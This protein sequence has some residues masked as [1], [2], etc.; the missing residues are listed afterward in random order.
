M[1]TFSSTATTTVAVHNAEELSTGYTAVPVKRFPRRAL[2]ETSEEKYWRNFKKRTEIPADFKGRTSCIDFC[3]RAPHLCAVTGQGKVLLFNPKTHEKVKELNPSDTVYC[4]RWRPDGKLLVT[5]GEKTGIRLWNLGSMKMLRELHGDPMG[6]KGHKRAVHSVH[7]LSDKQKLVSG[8]DDATVGVWDVATQ[9]LVNR[10]SGHSDYVRATAVHPLNP[11]II[12]SGS[13][14]KTVKVWDLRTPCTSAGSSYT[15]SDP[16]TSLQFHPAGAY[17]AAASATEVTLWDT[18]TSAASQTPVA[19]LAGHT[20][21]ITSMCFNFYGSRLLTGSIDRHVKV[22]ET[23]GYTAVHSMSFPEPVCSVGLSQDGLCLTVGGLAGKIYIRSRNPSQ[24]G[25][26]AEE[27]DVEA[28]L[29]QNAYA[30]EG[31]GAEDPALRELQLYSGFGDMTVERKRNWHVPTRSAPSHSKDFIVESAHEKRLRRYDVAFKKFNYHKAVDEVLAEKKSN[32]NRHDLFLTVITELHRRNGL[33][34]ALSG[35]DS[36][37]VLELLGYVKFGI[38]DPRRSD[39]MCLVLNLIV[40]IYHPVLHES[41]EI[42]H[43]V[44]GIRKKL[45]ARLTDLGDYE[46]VLGTV[47]ALS[48]QSKL[49]HLKRQRQAKVD[50]ADLPA[51]S[52]MDGETDED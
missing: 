24:G 52:S 22:Y 25:G 35:R 44:M 5:S 46:V 49:A 47:K 21:D 13:H 34:I 15:L 2:A 43:E 31:A 51:D 42:M 40:E 37:T 38:S 39:M 29:A 32:L 48:A 41:P 8:S 10:I 6:L 4:T 26:K 27:G 14:D 7:F 28:E 9:Q 45:D 17:I 11:N 18:A 16:V 33:R 30:E 12:A 20:K 36:T 50:G 3:P 1:A 23:E 19:T